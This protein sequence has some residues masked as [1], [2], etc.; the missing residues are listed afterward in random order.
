MKAVF[1]IV[2]IQFLCIMLDISG[3]VEAAD[4]KFK[5]SGYYLDDMLTYSPA[6][7]S[8]LFNTSQSDDFSILS[9]E[10]NRPQE[11]QCPSMNVIS[12]RYRCKVI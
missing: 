10:A 11:L 3:E 9:A 4:N 2:V 1:K 7:F 8:T 12:T 5:N 6:K